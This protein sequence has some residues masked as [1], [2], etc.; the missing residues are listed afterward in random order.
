MVDIKV[1]TKR[2]TKWLPGYANVNLFCDG[3]QFG[4]VTT[5]GWGDFQTRDEPIVTIQIEEPGRSQVMY[6]ISLSEFIAKLK[7]TLD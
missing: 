7:A 6:D 4:I 3:L 5:Q 2:S 1:Q